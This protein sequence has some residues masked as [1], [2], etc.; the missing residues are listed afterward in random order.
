VVAGMALYK[1]FVSDGAAAFWKGSI[2]IEAE[3]HGD[4]HA[5]SSYHAEG[6]ADESHTA[7]EYQSHAEEISAEEHHGGKHVPNWVLIAP[8]IAGSIGLILAIFQYTGANPLRPGLIREGGIVYGF[9]KNRWYIDH[10]YRLLFQRPAHMLGRFLWKRGDEGTI[11]GAGP[12][13][14]AGLM[15]VSAQRTV[16][17]QTGF[18]FHYAFV[19][20][21]GVVVLLFVLR[22]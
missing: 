10:L 19:M 22:A 5:S 12:N 17:I 16:G 9:L 3:A 6:H 8:L 15:N 11:D 18:V 2:H 13:G 14:V 21:L 7:H 20:M 1:P 4:D